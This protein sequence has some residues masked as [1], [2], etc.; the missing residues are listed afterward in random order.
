[1]KE[2]KVSSMIGPRARAPKRLSIIIPAYNEEDT[3]LEVLRR[4]EAVKLPLEKEIIVIDDGS[5]DCTR[6]LLLLEHRNG[7]F[8]LYLSPMNQGKGASIRTGFGLATG[9][10]VMVQDADRE[11]DPEDYPA[12]LAP[13]LAGQAEVVYGSRFSGRPVAWTVSYLGNRLMTWLSN[14]LYGGGITDLHTC[15]KVFR[16]EVIR[17]AQLTCKRFEFEP[18]VTAKILRLGHEI[19]EVPISYFPRT[20]ADG[21]KVRAKDAIECIHHL[22][23]WRFAGFEQLTTQPAFEPATELVPAAAGAGL[24]SPTLRQGKV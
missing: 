8:R 3:I 7:G 11:L 23:K 22:L 18:E 14:L 10:L 5:T 19:T 2:V 16:R 12:L 13:I 6:Q 24:T 17:N 1:M 15:Y 21:K 4:V 9:D 20:V